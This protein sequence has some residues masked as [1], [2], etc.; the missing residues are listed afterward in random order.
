MTIGSTSRATV[1]GA[2]SAALAFGSAAAFGSTMVLGSTT[3]EEAA[4]LWA[5]RS[6]AGEHE[7]FGCDKAAS[8]LP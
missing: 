6:V 3:R 8:D 4:R 7:G 1:G 5:V 2:S